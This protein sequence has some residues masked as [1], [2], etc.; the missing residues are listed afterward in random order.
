MVSVEMTEVDR[1]AGR[2]AV[3]DTLEEV[4]FLAGIPVMV[5]AIPMDQTEDGHPVMEMDTVADDHTHGLVA[6]PEAE[7]A[8]LA[9]ETRGDPTV[10]EMSRMKVTMADVGEVVAV[11]ASMSS[12]VGSSLSKSN[13]PG[14]SSALIEIRNGSATAPEGNRIRSRLLNPSPSSGSCCRLKKR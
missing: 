9:P 8:L 7:G 12:S 11:T 13:R 10:R 4:D 2:R 5:V 3:V 6:A 1:I 14:G